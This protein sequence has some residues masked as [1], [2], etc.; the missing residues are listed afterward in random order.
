MDFAKTRK[1]DIFSLASETQKRQKYMN[2][3]T[4]YIDVPIVLAT[5][6]GMPFVDTIE[7]VKHKKLGVVKGYA[8]QIDFKEKYPNIILVEV[9]S[10]HDGLDKVNNGEIFGYLDNS[11]VLNYHIQ[12]HHI[13]RLSISGKF[14]DHYRFSVATRVD[15][16]LLL[17]IFEKAVSS[18]TNS[19]K[20]LLYKK[21]ISVKI[22]RI[23]VIDYSLVYQIIAIA[24]VLLIFFA[25]W[26]R[27]I[28][29][30]NKELRQAKD[31]IKLLAYTDKLTGLYNRTK[32][33]ELFELE[34]E[35]CKRFNHSLII[36]ILDIDYF[37][38]VNDI[39]GHQVGD[40]VLAEIS[41]LLQQN[42]RTT[43]HIGRWGGEEFVIICTET[44]KANS[45]YFIEK[46]RAKIA[47]YDFTTVGTKTASFGVAQF[48]KNDT[49]KTIIKRADDALYTAKEIG[50]N[51]VVFN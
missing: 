26:N 6:I 33:D 18:I 19:E 8:L 28:T 4:P 32:L 5:K 49:I 35:K 9:D 14:E 43:D 30:I 23:K 20:E 11:L 7:Q 1:C 17:S 3:T 41:M 39:Y 47:S 37:K 34:I 42:V 2:F 48:Q 24:C 27:K 29:K 36:A 16:P 10:I 13:G 45:L 22:E 51:R 44:D 31:E 12:R 40:T 38:K 46:L 50:R 25:L 21:W 15:E